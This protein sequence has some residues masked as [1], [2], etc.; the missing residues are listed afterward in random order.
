MSVCLYVCMSC[1]G[2]CWRLEL[3]CEDYGRWIE[4]RDNL[5]ER[6]ENLFGDAPG[7]FPGFRPVWMLGL[8]FSFSIHGLQIVA[9]VPIIVYPPTHTHAHAQRKKMWFQFFENVRFCPKSF[10]FFSFLM[11]LSL[12]DFNLHQKKFRLKLKWNPRKSFNPRFS[13]A[14]AKKLYRG[15]VF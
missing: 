5:R 10:C 4:A 7:V 13:A 11:F 1:W 8:W 6:R 15:S 14:A 12:L 3:C 2:C 9:S